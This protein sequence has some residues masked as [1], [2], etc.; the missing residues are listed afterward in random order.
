MASKYPA[1]GLRS[2]GYA[3]M[4]FQMIPIPVNV[5]ASWFFNGECWGDKPCTDADPVLYEVDPDEY[6]HFSSCI[7]PKR[8]DA[9]NTERWVAKQEKKI[10]A[11]WTDDSRSVKGY[12]ARFGDDGPIATGTDGYNPPSYDGGFIDPFVDDE[13]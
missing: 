8:C 10:K 3:P 9:N 7:K 11:R 2:R 1:M 13:G 6:T 4:Y 5:K 12:V